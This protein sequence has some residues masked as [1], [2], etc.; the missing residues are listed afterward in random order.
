MLYRL[1]RYLL[2]DPMTRASL[3]LRRRIRRSWKRTARLHHLT[4]TDRTPTT[5][6][7]LTAPN[8]RPEPRVIAPA[9][10]TRV[11]R[12][13]VTIRMRTL[14]GIGPVEL[15]EAVSY[16]AATW[17]CPRVSVQVDKPGWLVLRAV[18]TDPLT[19]P[20]DYTPT[21]AAPTG[22]DLWT[23]PVGTDEY[24]APVL[25]PLNEVPGMTIG[26]LP[27]YGKTS[28]INSFIARLAPSGAV[29]FAVVDGKA[30]AAAQS[31]YT[32]LAD[33]LFRF[34]GSDL[35]EANRF[36]H[37]MVDLHARR[38][39][40]SRAM[41]GTQNMWQVGPSATWPWLVLVIDEAY[42]FFR[43][44][45][46]S[47]PQ[48]KKRAALAAENVRLVEHLVRQ[49][50]SAGILVILA[51]QKVTGDALPT[52]IRD[53]CSVSL[54]FAQRTTDAAVA[55]LGEDIRN[56]PDASPLL[57]QD[58]EYVGVA[59]MLT[60][61]RVG[62]LRVRT[63]YLSAADAGRIARETAHLTRDPATL[64]PPPPQGTDFTKAA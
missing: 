60:P 35:E 61:K 56:W 8:G 41:L 21:G 47:D 23:W 50:R 54:S 39:E 24:A 49:G 15:G 43:E 38:T 6:G 9:I 58:P 30:S 42:T 17:K 31:D 14:P 44:Q 5:A 4:V 51:T 26:G 11:D 63:P 29:Q 62:F 37:E 7:Q 48:T 27:G 36:F 53:V 20:V 45:K 18:H 52:S 2:A 55:A 12:V 13:G 34:V 22:K 32:D 25:Q 1:V 3:R 64:L 33:R 16:L 40:H 19:R 10:R 46:G 28:L 57:L 59:S